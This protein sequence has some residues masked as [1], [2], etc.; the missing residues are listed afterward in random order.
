[1]FQERVSFICALYSAHHLNNYLID[2]LLEEEPLVNTFI[3]VPKDLSKSYHY[4]Y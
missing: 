3:S 2:Y 1:M 4:I